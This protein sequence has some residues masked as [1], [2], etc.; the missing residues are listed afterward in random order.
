MALAASC[1]CLN[2]RLAL[3]GP[4]KTDF[5]L[6]DGPSAGFMATLV[7]GSI[8]V[9]HISLTEIRDRDH[10]QLKWVY[11]G[12]CKVE[13]YG[14]ENDDEK[15]RQV[16]VPLDARVAITRHALLGDDV[17][18]LQNSPHYSPLFRVVLPPAS[19]QQQQQQAAS[20]GRTDARGA[21]DE[22]AKELRR[23]R[24]VLDA[25]L[26]DFVTAETKA[27]NE[28]IERYRQD[29]L[30][31]LA[32]L[33]DKVSA[34]RDALFAAVRRLQLDDRGDPLQYT[35]SSTTA[36]EGHATA[37]TRRRTGSI[38]Y[39]AI[40]SGSN[41]GGVVESRHQ[42]GYLATSI[43]ASHQRTDLERFYSQTLRDADAAARATGPAKTTAPPPPTEKSENGTTHN[44]KRPRSKK[45]RSADSSG[46]FEL[47]DG[48][49]AENGAATTAD[50]GDD[51]D[52][53]SSGSSNSSDGFVKASSD[54][55]PEDDDDPSSSPRAQLPA[56]ATSLPVTVPRQLT[57]GAAAALRNVAATATAAPAAALSEA[58]APAPVP[59]D[60]QMPPHEYLAR[61][62]LAQDEGL[63]FGSRPEDKRYGSKI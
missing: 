38:S 26:N 35:A 47:D 43:A 13:V 46:V 54:D 17:Q 49:E 51:D 45:S 18:A 31:A 9:Q 10:C 52:S 19:S 44:A 41:V 22:V 16:L 33:T 4:P 48:I 42:A 11:C 55:K 40:I 53:S 2:V 3:T 7:A 60:E 6:Q 30:G 62:Y 25:T 5:V 50:D 23:I 8:T 1:R 59:E 57:H 56:F 15:S 12:G 32:E 27:A 20:N 63:L 28:R 21:V 24:G 36:A 39:D 14:V 37:A 34:E 61:T 58:A 29:Q